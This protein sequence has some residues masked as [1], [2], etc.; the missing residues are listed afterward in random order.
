MIDAGVFA[1]VVG[2]LYLVYDSED[3]VGQ[4]E[5]VGRSTAW[6]KT[7]FNCGLVAVKLSIVLQKFL[8]NSE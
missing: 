7:T 4:V 6:S 8:P 1:L 2:R 3:G 5:C